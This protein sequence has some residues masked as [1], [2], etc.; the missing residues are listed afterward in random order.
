MYPRWL[1]AV[2]H[3]VQREAKE[4]DYVLPRENKTIGASYCSLSVGICTEAGALVMHR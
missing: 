1:E 2:A 3:G 4:A